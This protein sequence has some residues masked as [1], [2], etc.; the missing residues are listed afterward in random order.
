MQMSWCHVALCSPS[1]AVSG[2]SLIPQRCTVPGRET[3]GIGRTVYCAT[4]TLK[5]RQMMIPAVLEGGVLTFFNPA[6]LNRHSWVW[7][8]TA[9]HQCQHAQHGSLWSP[10]ETCLGSHST[11]LYNGRMLS[12]LMYFDECNLSQYDSP[13]IWWMLLWSVHIVLGCGLVRLGAPEWTVRAC[14][15][16]GSSFVWRLFGCECPHTSLSC[17][18]RIRLNWGPSLFPTVSSIMRLLQA[19]A[20]HGATSVVTWQFGLGLYLQNQAKQ[21]AG[22]ELC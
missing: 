6:V 7:A 18:L 21:A 5:V 16:C 8:R 15:I 9:I 14:E 17:Y 2:A 20:W 11:R 4:Q 12:Q 22:S 3:G 10:C 1:A 13:G 19:Q